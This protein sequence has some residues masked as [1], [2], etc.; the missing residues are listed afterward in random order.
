MLAKVP[1]YLL[2]SRCN[3]P[4]IFHHK[5]CHKDS[6]STTKSHLHCCSI[7]R[8]RNIIIIITSVTHCNKRITNLIITIIVIVI[9]VITT[10]QCIK[11][12]YLIKIITILTAVTPFNSKFSINYSI[13]N[14]HLITIICHLHVEVTIAITSRE[15]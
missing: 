10:L 12:V 14:N 11:A 15:Q 1:F 4:C 9:T 13:N 2:Y 6:I 5:N 3:N 8:L 7:S